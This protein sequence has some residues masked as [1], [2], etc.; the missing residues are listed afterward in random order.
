MTSGGANRLAQAV[1]EACERAIQEPM[2][3]RPSFMEIV[4]ILECHKAIWV[5]EWLKSLGSE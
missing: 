1:Q 3:D 4:G 2:D 5:E